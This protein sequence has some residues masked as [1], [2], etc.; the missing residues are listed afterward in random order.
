MSQ[1]DFDLRLGLYHFLEQSGALSQGAVAIAEAKKTY[2]RLY[3]VQS[4]REHRKKNP[5]F[6]MSLSLKDKKLFAQAA[7]KHA[8][9]LST[10]LK[11]CA[12]AY[13]NKTY[14]VPNEKQLVHFEQKL[15]QIASDIRNMTGNKCADLQMVNAKLE[16]LE[17]MIRDAITNPDMMNPP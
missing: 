7:R 13:L 9:P 17:A 1:H 6:S 11:D 2:R 12:H 4:K 15:M 14:I 10:F 16:E 8:R 3:N 5:P